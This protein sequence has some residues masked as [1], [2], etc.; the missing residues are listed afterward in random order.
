MKNF[1]LVFLIALPS[2]SFAQSS[3]F[4]IHRE[5]IDAYKTSILIN[6]SESINSKNFFEEHALELGFTEVT[7]MKQINQSSDLVGFTHYRFKQ[8]YNDLEIYG[9]NYL[10]HEK[11]GKLVNGNG[12][13]IPE[14]NISTKASFS[15]AQ[16]IE[17]ARKELSIFSNS[18]EVNS[19]KLV[20][21]NENY[22]SFDGEFVLAYVLEMSVHSTIS[23]SRKII[24][25]AHNGKVIKNFTTQMSCFQD[26]GQ[27][28]TL[29]HRDR[30]IDTEKE[31]NRFVTK[32]LSRGSGIFVT[33]K[34]GH[35]YSDDD[36]H[37]ESGTI[38]YA[39]GV[40]D[41]IWGLEKT[42]DFY[43]D[44]FNRNG[45]NNAAL[46]IKA[47]LADKEVY[48][49]AFWSPTLFTLNFGIGD[50]VSN[51]Y[52]PLTSIDVV[53]HEFTHGVTQ[54]TASLEYLYEAGA[55]NE[56]FSD[57]IGKAIEYEFD[58][59]SFNWYIGGK[60]A[61]TKA[62]A[63]RNMED[64]NAY[65]N[66]KYYKGIK[67]STGTADNGGVHSNSGV[68]NYWY[69]LLCTGLKDTNEAKVIFDVKKFGF[70]TTTQFAY[71]LLTNYLGPTSSYYDAREASLLLATNLWGACSPEYNNIVEAWKAVGVGTGSID[72]DIQL[73]NS[74]TLLAACKDG[75]Y[76]VESRINNQ[77]CNKEIPAGTVI[78]MYYKL[79]TFKVV[80]ETLT[81]S[82]PIASGSHFNFVFST[83]PKIVKAGQSR[84]TVWMESVVDADTSNNRYSVLLNRLG[85]SIDQD[86]R[87]SNINIIGAPCPNLTN[88][89]LAFATANY[90]G[91]SVIP[92]GSDFELQFIFKDSISNYKFKN[93]TSV[94]PQGV[95]A[96]SNINIPRSFLGLK[97]VA[98]NLVWLKDT[99]LT[100]NKIGG[101]IVMINNRIINVVET[102]TSMS[103]DSTK[104]QVSSDSFNTTSIVAT[105][106]FNSEALITTG[107]K[108]LNNNG[109]FLPRV[110]ADLAS[111]I[112]SNPKFTSKIYVCADVVNIVQ[113]RIEFDLA[114]K[115][116]NYKYD[117]VGV[118]TPSATRIIFFDSLNTNLGVL[119]YSATDTD[120]TFQHISEDIPANTKFVEITNLCLKGG[121][122]PLSMGI[123][124][125]GDIVLVDN[126]VITGLTSSSNQQIEDIAI[127][128]NP[129]NGHFILFAE[130]NPISSMR[131]SN[132]I[133]EQI[134]SINFKVSV[135]Q[136]EFDILQN[137]SYF[138]NYRTESGKTGVKKIIVIK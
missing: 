38:D 51:N 120:F 114:Q 96:I 36:N 35:L 131:I 125:K 116:G 129:G 94:Y 12:T 92:A 80:N 110:Q 67:W 33:D 133:G 135:H 49:N 98:I 52:K 27:V 64:P 21:I 119:Y 117:S 18:F 121:I 1:T 32:D 87:M 7:Q 10:L 40:H 45:A 46:P 72:N 118:S 127:Q 42:Y 91:C 93:P 39:H 105:P 66:P 138:V 22:P 63:F 30:E 25:N 102:F 122:D 126:V 4:S 53:G 5:S 60:F 70:D 48:V 57:I 17:I 97:K 11:S 50:T 111:L 123:D 58:R 90:N 15:E 13:L 132:S 115:K 24:I 56:S 88:S 65:N 100:N 81:L 82:Q 47:F 14:Q 54:F 75:Y 61:K 103:F 37:W 95:M 112:Q 86:F 68:L 83:S 71:S 19:N 107:G 6:R 59:D 76:T 130:D 109:N 2:L 16:A 29:F 77:S 78:N 128:P 8:Y 113:P 99:F 41:L 106:T 104:I 79:D 20:I 73:V 134:Q 44:K 69:Y 9:S 85:S 84:L 124:P 101:Q 23:D 137:G 43:K 136:F 31:G 28:Q 55:M 34:A 26:K 62:L 89:Y 3:S 74:K 108:I